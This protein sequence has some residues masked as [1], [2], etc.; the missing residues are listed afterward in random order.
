VLPNFITKSVVAR[1]ACLTVNG[2][3]AIEAFK[4]LREHLVSSY[5]RNIAA[6]FAEPMVTRKDDRFEIAWYSE[7]VGEPV[8][9]LSL[10]PERRR[11][12]VDKLRT[13]LDALAPSLRDP[14]IGP[15]L[16]RALYIADARDI[17]AVGP[18]PMLINWGI[19]PEDLDARDTRALNDH[20]AVTLGPYASFRAPDIGSRPNAARPLPPPVEPT[21]V[22]AAPASQSPA[23]APATR[24]TWTETAGE[25]RALLIATAAAALVA[26]VL[27][28][29]GV[30]RTPAVAP[31]NNIDT[32]ATLRQITR[33]MEEKVAQARAAL[34]AAICN[35]DGSLGPAPG[36][37]NTMPQFPPPAM[38]LLPEESKGT[39][40]K[41]AE[42]ATQSVVFVFVCQDKKDW[43]TEAIKLKVKNP[44][45]ISCPSYGQA[46]TP[47]STPQRLVVAASGSGF[48]V[49]PKTVVTNMHVI[50]K[51]KA[52]F[53]TNRYLG[54]VHSAT[55]IAATIKHHVADPDFAVLKV[56]TDRSPPPIQLTDQVSRLQNVVA[57]GYP[58]VIIDEDVELKRLFEDGDV[59][60]VPELTTFPGF[61]T[62][63]MD[64]KSNLPLI[65]SSA[66]IGH[67]NSGGPLLDLC[68]R[69]VGM[70]TLGWSGKAQDTGYK[71][72]VA[73]GAKG[74]MAFLRKSGVIFQQAEGQ[75]RPA[76]APSASK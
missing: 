23:P 64:A 1:R 74:L 6:L 65:F 52:I 28:L 11:I 60:A 55:L 39:M 41:V 54:Q 43:E 2:E 63:T 76:A 40:S 36:K 75:C 4:Q 35:P 37:I 58:G 50:A 61:V 57:A 51:A 53:V 3:A 68:A 7:L 31:G 42:R 21:V 67:G 72:N 25:Q 49:G 56:D 70:N 26:L 24:S 32:L 66:V 12:L 34:V 59:K 8:P 71:V 5:G 29:P 47:S 46:A 69:A 18:E 38:P 62:L 9:L 27:T 17:L 20:F 16:A 19:V 15:L 14:A 22:A 10:D 13:Q 30:L 45:A 48:F 44:Q 33:T 73:E